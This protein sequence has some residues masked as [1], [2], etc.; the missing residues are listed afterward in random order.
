M[1]QPDFVRTVGPVFEHSPWI[2]ERASERRPFES[3]DDLRAALCDT[4]DAAGEAEKLALIRAHPDLVGRAV[5]TAESQGEQAAAGLLELTPEESGLFAQYNR[6]YRE[7]FDF[8]FVICARLNKKE[9]I[10]DA[11][12]RRLKNS[13]AEEI[14]T[15]LEEIFKIA[16]LRLADLINDE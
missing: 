16:Q 14:Q 1:P 2:A 9:A 12:P 11:F 7:R 15:A 10:L 6:E 4:V 3:A 13:R 5:L 8:P